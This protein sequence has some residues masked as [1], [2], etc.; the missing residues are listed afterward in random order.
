MPRIKREPNQFK[1]DQNGCITLLGTDFYL[2]DKLSGETVKIYIDKFEIYAVA[3]EP[4][5]RYALMRRAEK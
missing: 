2:S 3:K 5:V 4:T 1:V